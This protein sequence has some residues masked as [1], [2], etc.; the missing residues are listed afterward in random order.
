MSPS[1]SRRFSPPPPD[2][3]AGGRPAAPEELQEMAE[4]ERQWASAS[5]VL[6]PAVVPMPNDLLAD[7]D[8][9]R[10]PQLVE[11]IA[12]GDEGPIFSALAQ[13][14][15]RPAEQRDDDIGFA[16]EKAIEYKQ[17]RSLSVLIDGGIR[18]TLRQM[19]HAVTSGDIPLV[20]RFL[21]ELPESINTQ[22]PETGNTA[23]TLAVSHRELVVWLLLHGADPNLQDGWSE[24]PLSRAVEHGA[25]EV[26]D[27]LLRAGADVKLGAPLYQ[28]LLIEDESQRLSTMERLLALGAPVNKYV[29]EGSWVWDWIGFERGTA[30][31]HACK[32]RN[33]DA[34]KLLLAHGADPS[35]KEKLLSDDLEHSTALDEATRRNFLEIVAVLQSA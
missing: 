8:I 7:F 17:L 32:R 24:T 16:I 33:L 26:V 20:Q 3:L 9:T 25:L 21:D 22:S 1:A 14:R 28:A 13:I 5:P 35:L 12:H 34:V 31:H 29:G 6:I 11:T 15:E 18:V 19:H 10:L 2:V 27:I 23:L 30:L 4:L